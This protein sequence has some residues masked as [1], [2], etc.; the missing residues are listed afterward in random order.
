MST[1]FRIY[2]WDFSAQQPQ[3]ELL[4][5]AQRPNGTRVR[6]VLFTG[7]RPA[8][9]D[10]HDK[11]GLVQEKAEPGTVWE[12]EVAHQNGPYPVTGGLGV[13]IDVQ[14]TLVETTLSGNDYKDRKR[15]L[16]FPAH[17]L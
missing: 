14:V 16:G 8:D 12:I 7:M 10:R 5:E 1:R 3:G 2:G 13:G 17:Q 11:V 15:K 6:D 9:W 4:S